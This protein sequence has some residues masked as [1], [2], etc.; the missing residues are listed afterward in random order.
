MENERK[1]FVIVS[2]CFNEENLILQFLKEIEEICSNIDCSFTIVIVDDGSTDQTVS[3]IQSV[4]L[5]KAN[6]D[7]RLIS[8]KYNMG[9]QEAIKQGLIYAQSI[10]ANGYIIMDSDGEDDPLAILQL[11]EKEGEADIVFV[12]RGRRMESNK[13]KVG[14][15]FYRLLF[16]IISGN[17]INFGNYSLISKKVLSATVLQNFVHYSAFLSKQKFTKK[18]ICFDRRKRID[19]KS[20]MNTNSLILHGLNSLIEYSDELLMFFIKLLGLLF[21]TFTSYGVYVLYSKFVSHEAA[22][23]WASVILISLINLILIISTFIISGLLIMSQKKNNR[24]NQSLYNE[25]EN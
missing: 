7:L 3:V 17:R 15:F 8:L 6:F 23:G 1:H 21:L 2:P 24:K 22:T 14:Y 5:H 19:G 12:S 18:F 13:F 16:K 11:V 20:K 4:D 25:I 10:S 9:H